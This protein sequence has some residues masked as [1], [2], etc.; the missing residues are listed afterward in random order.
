MT[1]YKESM[2]LYVLNG[3]G[4]LSTNHDDK[5]TLRLFKDDYKADGRPDSKINKGIGLTESWRDC[6][7][8]EYDMKDGKR[9]VAGYHNGLKEPNTAYIGMAEYESLP[10]AMKAQ[11]IE[12]YKKCI[13]LAD[14]IKL[15]FEASTVALRITNLFDRLLDRRYGLALEQMAKLVEMGVLKYKPSVDEPSERNIYNAIRQR[16]L[17]AKQMFEYE[18]DTLVIGSIGRPIYESLRQS[19]TEKMVLKENTVY[20]QG[21]NKSSKPRKAVKVY[22]APARDGKEA[23]KL[24]KIETTLY[25]PYFNDNQISVDM[26]TTQPNIQELIKDEIE[27]SLVSVLS[28]VSRE[29]LVM[30]AEA[31]AVESRDIKAMPRQIA[32]QMLGRTLT[33]DVAEL[34]RKVAEHDRRIS[35]LEQGKK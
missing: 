35:A 13:P 7:D 20:L 10:D 22:D 5:L 4:G 3:I 1:D 11:W 33:Q 25:T 34:K 28:K 9:I 17:R 14:G 29:V 23:G 6:P 32:R 8:I 26:L 12:Y 31:Y 24:Y 15:A 18:H 27:D 16:I 19:Q 30:T 2:A 21:Y